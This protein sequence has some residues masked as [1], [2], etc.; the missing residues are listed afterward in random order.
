MTTLA[1]TASNARTPDAAEQH[2]RRIGL[3][4]AGQSWMRLARA[5]PLI[6][7]RD[8]RPT[9]CSALVAGSDADGDQVVR[10]PGRAPLLSLTP[11]ASWTVNAQTGRRGR[12]EGA[13]QPVHAATRGDPHP[14]DATSSPLSSG[15][16]ARTPTGARSPRSTCTAS[17]PRGRWGR[18]KPVLALTAQDGDRCTTAGAPARV[19]ADRYGLLTPGAQCCT[20]REVHHCLAGDDGLVLTPSG[21]AGRDGGAGGAEQVGGRRWG[22]GGGR[23]LAARDRDPVGHVACHGLTWGASGRQRLVRVIGWAQPPGAHTP[24]ALELLASL[25]LDRQRGVV[26]YR[27]GEAVVSEHGVGW[28]NVD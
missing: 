22:D 11:G 16:S 8:R 15:N 17:R 2:E 4:G 7:A 12:G 27:L 24:D 10:R 18:Q 23:D 25:S 20:Q 1:L 6:P 5:I 26:R 21:Q 28:G 14:A 19:R 3:D 9:T 13:A